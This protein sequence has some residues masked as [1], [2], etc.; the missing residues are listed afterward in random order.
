VQRSLAVEIAIVVG[1]GVISAGAVT[2][3]VVLVVLLPS[4]FGFLILA[5]ASNYG[6]IHVSLSLIVASIATWAL[7]LSPGALLLA[8]MLAST[9][10]ALVGGVVGSFLG[11]LSAAF[12]L[13]R[14][15]AGDDVD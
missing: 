9:I 10:G 1:A 13:H 15:S 11:Y 6:V 3:G 8:W 14:A 4:I 5:A 7:R 2:V 12:V